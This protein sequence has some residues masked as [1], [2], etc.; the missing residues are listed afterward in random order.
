AVSAVA[1]LKAPPLAP[2]GSLVAGG[3]LF[4]ATSDPSGAS[5]GA[6][7]RATALTASPRS[8]EKKAFKCAHERFRETRT[9][10]PLAIRAKVP[11]P[12]KV[13]RLAVGSSQSGIKS[14]GCVQG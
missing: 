3:G 2:L 14:C 13:P 11:S 12:R 1:L 10:R 6:F 8:T 7:S 5:G 4:P 9:R